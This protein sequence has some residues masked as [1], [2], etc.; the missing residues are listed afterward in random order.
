MT[1]AEEAYAR[2][3]REDVAGWF[4]ELEALMFVAVSR[5]Q[6]GWLSGD[7]LKIGAYCGKSAILLG[8]LKQPTER[9]TVVDLFESEKPS[10]EIAVEHRRFYEGLTLDRFRVTFS[11]YHDWKPDVLVG[12]SAEVLFEVASSTVRFVHVDGSHSYDAVRADIAHAR[13]V[14]L[15][16]GVVAF[17]DMFTAHTPGV[18][19]A[20]WAEVANDLR[21]LV[22]GRKLYATWSSRPELVQQRLLDELAALGDVL[23]GATHVIGNDPVYEVA[24]AKAPPAEPKTTR[25]VRGLRRLPQVAYHALLRT[26]VERA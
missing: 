2:V 23:V 18:Q 12:D 17:D 15:P 5:S 11:R 16:D 4:D 10:E 26:R 21:P 20:V 14:L 8:M 22:M 1:C 25:L 24:L 6:V 7:L 13:R 19:A 3:G 9:L